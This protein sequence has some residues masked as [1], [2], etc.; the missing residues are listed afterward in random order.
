MTDSVQTPTPDFNVSALDP[1]T[2]EEP[3]ELIPVVVVKSEYRWSD[4]KY[5]G[6]TAFRAALPRPI[7]QW[8]LELERLDAEFALLDGTRAPVIMYAGADLEKLQKDGTLQKIMRTRGKEN[9]V[10]GAWTQHVGV[11]NLVPDPGKIIGMKLVVARYREKDITGNGFF[12]KNVIVPVETLT[13]TYTYMGDKRVFTQT[14]PNDVNEGDVQSAAAAGF[15][16]APSISKEEAAAKIGSFLSANSITDL[17]SAVLGHPD[18]PAEARI[19]PFIS[20]FA[21]GSAL[22][23]L[24]GFGVAV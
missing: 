20:A 24:A 14:R 16:G 5:N 22:E 8:N 17:D 21:T 9:F 13:P 6:A 7:Q 11:A 18:F 10:V 1:S 3:K 4:A 19:E 15:G 12:A 2:W 23:T